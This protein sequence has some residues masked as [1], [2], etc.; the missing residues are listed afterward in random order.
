MSDYRRVDQRIDQTRPGRRNFLGKAAVAGGAATLAALSGC[1]V[2]SNNNPT[3][4]SASTASG[5]DCSLPEV[6]IRCL[7]LQPSSTGSSRSFRAG[8]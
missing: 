5:G 3:Q 6:R 1:G 8:A 2:G 7:K 4:Q